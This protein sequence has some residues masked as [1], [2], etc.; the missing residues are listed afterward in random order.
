MKEIEAQCR[1]EFNEKKTQVKTHLDEQNSWLSNLEKDRSEQENMLK[2]EYNR[3]ISDLELEIRKYK[4]LYGVTIPVRDGRDFHSGDLQGSAHQQQADDPEL[5]RLHSLLEK[6]R[7][8][9]EKLENRLEKMVDRDIDARAQILAERQRN[10]DVSSPMTPVRRS[11]NTSILPTS[12][13]NTSGYY[14]TQGLR[15]RSS[16][17]PCWN[18]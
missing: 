11:Y 9:R 12:T 18:V 10:A 6:E 15:T 13:Q 8:Q 3:R 1:L 14:S 16:S 5:K 7:K 2:R 4:D 17:T